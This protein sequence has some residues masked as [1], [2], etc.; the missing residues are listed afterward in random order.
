MCV[1]KLELEFLMF[2]EYVYFLSV[3]VKYTKKENVYVYLFSFYY[4]LLC[5]I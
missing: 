3:Q 4:F 1:F 2:C 5:V